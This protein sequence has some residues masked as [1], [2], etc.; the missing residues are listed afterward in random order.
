[1]GDIAEQDL[2][3]LRRRCESLLQLVIPISLT[4]F[5]ERDFKSLLERVLL[6]ARALC[7]ADGGTLYLCDQENEHLEFAIVH[8]QTLGI[9]MGG[10]SGVPPAFPAL[11]LRDPQTLEPNHHNIATYV[12]LTGSP[13]CIDDAYTAEGFD[14]SGTRRFDQKTGYRSKSLLTLPLKNVD[15]RVIGV[16]QLI[17]ALDDD[18]QIVSFDMDLMPIVNALTN[19]AAAALEQVVREN[20]L[21]DKIQQLQVH[22]DQSRRARQVTEITKSQY[23][24]SL[25]AKAKALRE[26]FAAPTVAEEVEECHA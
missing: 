3:L 11:P 21:K 7:H 1:M 19:L 17:N 10:S 12:A 9:S 18:G 26:Q 8:N 25:A 5:R 4:L 23:F 14:F 16:L 15:G 20:G 6:E 13:I 2:Q 24:K 22:I